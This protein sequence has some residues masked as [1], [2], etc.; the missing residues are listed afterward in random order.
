LANEESLAD[1]F[2]RGG[3]AVLQK[4]GPLADGIVEWI[5][6]AALSRP[7]TPDEAAAARDLLGNAPTKESVADCLWAMAMLPE[8]QLIR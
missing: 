3:A 8:F 6:A 4:H 5:F 2:I 7:P 1:E